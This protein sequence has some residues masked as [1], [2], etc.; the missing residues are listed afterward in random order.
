M[1]MA[2]NTSFKVAI[3]PTGVISLTFGV[4]LKGTAFTITGAVLV[5]ALVSG[6]PIRCGRLPVGIELPLSV[7][8][9]YSQAL[10]IE[11]SSKII[12]LGET[13]AENVFSQVE[14]PFAISSSDNFNGIIT[15][16][17]DAIVLNTGEL[18]NFSTTIKEKQV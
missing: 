13:E 7:R 2:T 17:N 12:L 4:Q 6:T 18:L 9:G 10:T 16:N 1:T 15:A 8:F 5:N 3:I 14:G 11:H